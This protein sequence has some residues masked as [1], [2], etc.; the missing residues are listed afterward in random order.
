MRIGASYTELWGYPPYHPAMMVAL[1]L[2]AYSRGVIPRA[3]LPVA[4]RSGLTS[5]RHAEP[6]FLDVHN[7]LRRHRNPGKPLTRAGSQPF[8][9]C[10]HSKTVRHSPGEVESYAAGK[11]NS[12]TPTG[13]QTAPTVRP[14]ASSTG[15]ASPHLAFATW[16]ARAGG[17]YIREILLGGG[18]GGQLRDSGVQGG[19]RSG[20]RRRLQDRNGW[21][22]PEVRLIDRRSCGTVPRAWNMRQ[23]QVAWHVAVSAVAKDGQ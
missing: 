14:F 12:Q 1:L 2:Y 8:S 6:C 18:G 15:P 4:A 9:F 5:R 21:N 11:W 10:S 13:H 7:W 16:P 23:D 17:C 22:I 3:G 19:I 20:V